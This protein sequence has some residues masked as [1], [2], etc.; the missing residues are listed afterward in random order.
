MQIN[1]NNARD[2]LEFLLEHV[3]ET[4]AR[5]VLEQDGQVVAGLIGVADLKRLERLDTL[6]HPNQQTSLVGSVIRFDDPFEPVWD[7]SNLET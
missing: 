2:Q 5:V 7:Q 3:R 1:I 6:E 4:G